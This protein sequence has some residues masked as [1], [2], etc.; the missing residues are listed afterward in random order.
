MDYLDTLKKIKDSIS[1]GKELIVS[2]KLIIIDLISKEEQ[3]FSA[4]EDSFV[5]FYEDV[6]QKKITFNFEAALTRPVYELA[7]DDAQNCINVSQSV[8]KLED[9]SSLYT[10]LQNAIKFTD[11]LALHYLQNIINEVP[12]KQND[13]GTERSRYI[14][15]N[16]KKNGAEKAG[17]ILSS[18]YD[19]RNKMEHRKVSDAND[20]NKQ[21]IIPPNYKRIRRQ[22]QKRYPEALIC[23]HDSFINNN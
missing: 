12:V 19:C 13:A 20:E 2:H 11:N 18:L 3:S 15:I 23:F 10:W 6:I 4:G 7:Q 9:N 14:Q 22:I 5:Y 16:Q 17:R 8:T 21:K 1:S